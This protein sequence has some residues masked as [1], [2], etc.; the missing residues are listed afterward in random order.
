MNLRVVDSLSGIDSDQWNALTDDHPLVS[1]EFLY[2]LEDT[3]CVGPGTGWEP[4]HLVVEEQDGGLVGALPLYL[5]TD[6]WGEFVF[7]FAWA[8]AYRRAGLAYYP[9]LVSAVPFT[10]AAGPRLLIHPERV[11]VSAIEADLIAGARALATDEDASS[12]HFLF[13]SS[14]D[15][16]V[17]RNEGLMLRKDCQFHWHNRGYAEF[18]EF[19]AGFS[20]SRRK[21]TRRE[22][23]RV[24]EAGIR[25]EWIP[26]EELS[27]EQWDRLM[28]LYAATFMRRGRPPYLTEGFFSRFAA[29]APG[30]MVLI[31]GRRG[32]DPMG[33]A[34]CF[35]G[36]ETLYG[37]Y[38]GSA[39]RIHSLHFETCYYQGIDYCIKHGIKR[40]EPGTQGEHKIARGFEPTATWSAHWMAHPAFADAV[41]HYLKEE[42]S[43]ID[44][45]ISEAER[46]L[47][48]RHDSAGEP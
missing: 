46:H 12:L 5:K 35:K 19:L 16:H 21:K 20:A 32:S 13:A 30:S 18:D 42:T 22:R 47:P 9:K 6:S 15:R 38:W 34:I 31:V 1:W 27:R 25:F 14:R 26:G 11:D 10:P 36:S 24:R 40:F 39:E 45:Y 7:D 43:Y 2:T 44:R 17:L 33:L 4:R 28:P 41:G 29:R 23:R 37:R 48:Y 8:D 3:R